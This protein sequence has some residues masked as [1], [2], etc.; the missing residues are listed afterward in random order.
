VNVVGI[1]FI[2]KISLIS[3]A[4]SSLIIFELGNIDFGSLGD[5]LFF[6]FK[7][8]VNL[9]V[10]GFLFFCYKEGY[11]L[12]QFNSSIELSVTMELSEESSEL[13]C[14]EKRSSNSNKQC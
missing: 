8:D 3:L 1:I 9:L 5:F 4:V 10:G 13:K 2:D 7:E 6:Y 14:A 11:V 12:F